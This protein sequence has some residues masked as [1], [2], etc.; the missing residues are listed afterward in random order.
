MT[1]I[2]QILAAL[3]L[4]VSLLAGGMLYMY[5]QSVAENATLEANNATLA[6]AQAQTVAALAEKERMRGI[7]EDL[8]AET[9]IERDYIAR[10]K[11]EVITIIKSIEVPADASPEVKCIKAPVHPIADDV[12]SR[13]WIDPESG[14]GPAD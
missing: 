14:N 6:F 8:L 1:V 7:T 5:K 11:A 10:E 9:I 3:L 2:T 12:L 13:L 4:G